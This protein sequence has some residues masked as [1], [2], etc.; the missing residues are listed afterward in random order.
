MLFAN[1]EHKDDGPRS[2]VAECLGKLAGLDGLKIIPRLHDR[3][4]YSSAAMR[5][6]NVCEVIIHHIWRLKFARYSGGGNCSTFCHPRK[7]L[8]VASRAHEKLPF[9]DR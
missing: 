4:R 3:V 9:V 2:V 6:N 5:G 7:Q 1:A 8:D